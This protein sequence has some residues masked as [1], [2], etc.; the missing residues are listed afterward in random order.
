MN[1]AYAY[2]R[3]GDR[4]SGLKAL[5]RAQELA[6]TPFAAAISHLDEQFKAWTPDVVG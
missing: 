6:T 1:Q 4:K 3:L 5:G 2:V